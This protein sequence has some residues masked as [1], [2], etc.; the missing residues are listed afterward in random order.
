MKI[1]AK[2]GKMRKAVEWTV[3]PAQKDGR[4]ILQSSNYIAAFGGPSGSIPPGRALLS[5]RQGG[6]AYFMHL[7]PMCGATLVDIPSEVIQ[8]ALDAV[9]QKGD[10]IG[11]GVYVG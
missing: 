8:E 11:G 2:L 1:T 6:G 10:H 9:P 7:S 4:V 5:K 3:Y